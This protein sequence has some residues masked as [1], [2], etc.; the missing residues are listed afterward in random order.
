MRTPA[1]FWL[2]AFFLGLLG[3]SAVIVSSGAWA[4]PSLGGSSAA[5]SSPVVLRPSAGA[6]ATAIAAGASHTCVLTRAGGV[7]CWGLNVAGQLGDGT[8]IGRYTPVAVS[9]L[10]SGV[11]AISAGGGQTC[12]LT[13]AGAVECWGWNLF[14]QLGDGT[15]ITSLK[16]VAVSGL[17]SG[18]AAIAAGYAHTCALTNAGAVKCWGLNESGQLGDGTT[19][20]RYT[21]VAVS[22]LAS[23]VTAITTGHYHSCALTSAGGAK[24]WGLNNSGWLGDGTTTRR[25]MPVA[26]SGLTSGVAV[27]S[28]GN[29]HTCA[30]RSAGAVKCWGENGS[31]QLGDGTKIDRHRPIAVSGLAS[32]VTAITAGDSLYNEAP[33]GYSSGKGRRSPASSRS[34]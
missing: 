26:V 1:C 31:G 9:G 22:G 16:P 17:A 18:V 10:A 6:T 28:A 13:S 15:T 34:A 30:L 12:A 7:E 24:C 14:G 33:A 3:A 19:I 11:T 29:Y 2:R 21:P 32:G 8:T 25:L 4:K 27:I 20:G 23:A 5:G